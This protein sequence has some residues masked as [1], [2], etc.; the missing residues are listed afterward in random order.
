MGDYQYFLHYEENIVASLLQL[1][2]TR[3]TQL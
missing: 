1:V 3:E 2:Y